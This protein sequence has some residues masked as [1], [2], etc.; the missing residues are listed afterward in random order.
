MTVIKG[1]LPLPSDSTVPRYRYLALRD[2]NNRL[3]YRVIPALTSWYL[4]TGLLVIGY[5]QKAKREDEGK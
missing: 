3:I 5:T 1:G 4:L 2:M